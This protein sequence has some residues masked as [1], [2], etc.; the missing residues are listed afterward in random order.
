[1]NHCTGAPAEQWLERYIQGTLPDAESQQFEEHYFDCP[2]CLAQVEAM[3]AVRA[4]LAEL[5]AS[6]LPSKQPLAKKRAP[7]L[8]WPTAAAAVAALAASL[9]IVVLGERL[10]L[11]RIL[12]PNVTIQTGPQ[13][14]T[15]PHPGANSQTSTTIPSTSVVQLADLTLPPFRAATL[16]GA[17]EDSDFAAGMK[18]Y[19][20]GDCRA[21]L[22]A[23]S[24]ASAS[25]ASA[26]ASKFYSGVCQM[27]LGDLPAAAATFQRV[28]S[29]GDSPQQEAAFYYQAQIALARNDATSARQNLDRT[30]ALHGDFEQ[31][32]RRQSAALAAAGKR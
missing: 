1:M 13:S 14:P 7:I 5:P 11:P 3:Q 10:L 30:L 21:A 23:L 4:R 12:P 19:S 32:A 17:N 24:R 29:A 27:H 16:R 28:A 20:A 26:L 31:R 8:A 18:D 6:E 15:N 25:G 9:L 22:T 2:V